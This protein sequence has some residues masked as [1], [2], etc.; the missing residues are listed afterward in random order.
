M[1]R[2]RSSGAVDIGRPCRNC[3]ARLASDNQGEL[4][5]PC[6][7]TGAADLTAPPNVSAEFWV[8][9]DM[10]AAFATRHMGR[11][12]RAYRL[13]S[14]HGRRGPSQDHVAAWA[15]MSQGWISQLENGPPINQLDRLIQWARLLGIPPE[16]LWFDLPD[17]A[18]AADDAGPGRPALS[19][20]D[21]EVSAKV[22]AIPSPRAEHTSVGDSDNDPLAAER[23]AALGPDLWELHDVLQARR[24]S[25]GSLA[26]AEEACARFDARYA[27]LPPLVLLPELRRQLKHVVGW[28]QESQPV[29]Y[30]QRLCSLAARL[31]GLRAWLY[32]DMAD[33]RAADAWFASAANAASEAD[34]RNLGGWLL[35]ARSL[36]PVDRQ[37]YTAAAG[38]LG[39]AQALAGAGASPTTRAWLDALE[40]RALA[41]LGDERGFDAAQQRATK[42][43]T[44]TCVDDR[45][46]GMDFAGPRLD[47]SYYDGLSYLLVGRASA[48]EAAFRQALDHLPDSRIKA[49]SILLLSVALAAAEAGRLDEAVALTGQALT[50]ASDQ[51]IRRVWQRASE[52]RLAL[53]P[54]DRSSPVRDLDE[55]L[56]AFVGSL[57]AVGST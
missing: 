12:I 4:C 24:V 45:H 44:R 9:P 1:V 54:A 42:R 21:T 6:E 34:D 35:G 20:E 8:H 18:R 38:M 23:A 47:L 41:G 5:R 39:E 57:E 43:L 2:S 19:A 16:Y 3:D 25:A 49:R 22:V 36:I 52:V 46:H 11:V 31:A 53:A 28:L 29:S 32:F 33:Y 15:G 55:Q 48:A 30:R 56:A 27:E 13:H 7:A 17:G 10:Q 14:H 40:A 37:D 26:L 50:L 51:P